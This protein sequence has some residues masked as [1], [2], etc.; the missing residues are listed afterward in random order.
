MNSIYAMDVVM[1]FKQTISYQNTSDCRTLLIVEPWAEQYLIEPGGKVDIIG[2][3]GEP[4]SGFEIKH[5]NDE[6]I[7]F[8]WTGSVVRVWRNGVEVAPSDQA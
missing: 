4:S 1:K 7:I 2:E 8:G 5:T 6:L 3:G